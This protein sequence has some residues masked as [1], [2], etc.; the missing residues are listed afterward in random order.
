MVRRGGQEG[1]GR[2][3]VLRQNDSARDARSSRTAKAGDCR[4]NGAGEPARGT[5]SHLNVLTWGSWREHRVVLP[6][7]LSF[8]DRLASIRLLELGSWRGSAQGLVPTGAAVHVDTWE[9]QSWCR[10]GRGGALGTWD[11]ADP[12]VRSCKNVSTT[13]N[14]AWRV[15]CVGNRTGAAARVW[16][17]SCIIGRR[18]EWERSK[19]TT[20]GGLP[21]WSRV[22]ADGVWV[23]Y[24][25][26]VGQTGNAIGQP[27][28]CYCYCCRHAH[29][30]SHTI[31]APNHLQLW[32]LLPLPSVSRAPR[33][34]GRQS[35]PAESEH[36]GA[37]R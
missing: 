8:P 35:H 33:E 22:L 4:A 32:P 26:T 11:Y 23:R 27:H 15:R 17:S 31:V 1:R 34:H 2:P 18:W 16:G 7:G 3:I 29:L 30:A 13:W 6:D 20:Q 14:L 25:C 10:V 5:R 9:A 24:Q 12:P 37:H 36:F 21:Q 28:S 19:E